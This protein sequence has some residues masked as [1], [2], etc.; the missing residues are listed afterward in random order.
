MTT[1]TTDLRSAVQQALDA[2]GKWSSGR[3]MDAVQLNDLIATLESALEQPDGP[4]PTCVALARTVMV[5]QMEVGQ[6]D[7]DF[8]SRQFM[9]EELGSLLAWAL[10]IFAVVALLGFLVGVLV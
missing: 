9:L 7:P 6:D 10:G 2:L 8:Y 5:D 3:D 4:C 1:T